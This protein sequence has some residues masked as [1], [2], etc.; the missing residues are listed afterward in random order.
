ML[1]V[2]LDLRDKCYSNI[3]NAVS[4]FGFEKFDQQHLNKLQVLVYQMYVNESFWINL[5]VAHHS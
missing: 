1:L 5:T 3:S 4:S 2:F